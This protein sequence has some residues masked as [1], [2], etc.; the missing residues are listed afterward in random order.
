VFDIGVVCDICAVQ[1]S[2]LRGSP[3]GEAVKTDRIKKINSYIRW[4]TNEYMGHV[5][6]ACRL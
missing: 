1:F 3:F 5:S 4:L 6:A 2:C